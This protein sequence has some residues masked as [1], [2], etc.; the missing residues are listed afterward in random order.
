MN[1]PNYLVEK[2]DDYDTF[3]SIFKNTQSLKKGHY[4]KRNFFKHD[5]VVTTNENKKVYGFTHNERGP[6][7][8]VYMKPYK[9][10]APERAAIEEIV[11]EWRENET[12]YCFFITLD[13]EHGYLQIPLTEKAKQKTPFITP[14]ETGRFE[15]M[16]FGLT[17]STEELQRLMYLVLDPFC[18]L[19]VLCY[20]DDILITAKTWEEIIEKLIEVFERF[21]SA[22]VTLKL[23][24]CKFG[25]QEVDN[26]G[27]V[28]NKNLIKPGSR[29]LEAIFK[30]PQP[31]NMHDARRFL[32]LKSLFRKF[33]PNHAIKYLTQ[34]PEKNKIFKLEKVQ[35]EWFETLKRELMNKPIFALCNPKAKTEEHT[36]AC[37]DGIAGILLQL[38]SDNKWHLVYCES[39]ITT[40]TENKYH[41]SKLE[42]MATV[43]TLV[44]LRQFLLGI[45]FTAMTDCQALI[46][47]NVKKSSNP[48]IARW[49][50]LIEEFN[51]EIRHR[52]GTKMS[53]IDAISRAPV[54]ISSDTLDSLIENKSEFCLTLSVE[55]QVL[56]M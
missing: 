34:L 24:K 53:H 29:K 55:Y 17:N 45:S 51:F 8:P 11:R 22:N 49:N 52:P 41:S 47:M 56:M 30:F 21:R 46:Y 20:L 50:R 2:L 4:D 10:N 27:F 33:I 54:L 40:E 43:W 48:Q 28:I 15:R 7:K 26:L 18:N 1:S 42:L 36:Y 19:G 44:Q 5:P 12:V 25:K 6:S 3:R 32:G 39:N 37:V 38:G 14:D 23:P 16:N 31:K 35:E 9:T 13:L